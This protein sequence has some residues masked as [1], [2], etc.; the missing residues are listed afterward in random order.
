MIIII[1]QYWDDGNF[2]FF[3]FLKALK[4]SWAL[5]FHSRKS[6]IISRS[7]NQ[8]KE[9]LKMIFRDAEINSYRIG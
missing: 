7:K 3:F 6:K 9:I 4:V 5:I 1:L 8:E 2:M